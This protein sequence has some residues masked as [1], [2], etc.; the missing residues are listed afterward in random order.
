MRQPTPNKLNPCARIIGEL[1]Q[2]CFLICEETKFDAE[3]S[4]A[5]HVS[6]L[7]ISVKPEGRYTAGALLELDEYVTIAPPRSGWGEL[8]RMG[9]DTYPKLKAFLAELKK[10]HQKNLTE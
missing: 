6:E 3:F 9:E 4:W 10:F 2:V 5:A 1:A 8:G 7:M